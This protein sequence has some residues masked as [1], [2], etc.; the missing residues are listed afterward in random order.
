ML[1][2]GCGTSSRNQNKNLKFVSH[3]LVNGDIDIRLK[4]QWGKALVNLVKG[5]SFGNII[6]TQSNSELVKVAC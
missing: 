2:M 3:S 5:M 1:L 4:F 6:Y